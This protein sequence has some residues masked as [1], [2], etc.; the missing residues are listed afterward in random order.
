MIN[1][2]RPVGLFWAYFY[3]G[4][5]HRKSWVMS[6]CRELDLPALIETAATTQ[7][8]RMAS[9]FVCSRP[10]LGNAKGSSRPE[11]EFRFADQAA[12]H[13]NP[14]PTTH[15]LGDLPCLWLQMVIPAS[16]SCHEDLRKETCRI[17]SKLSINAR[18][19]LPITPTAS[20]NFPCCLH[21]FLPS[22]LSSHPLLL[23]SNT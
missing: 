6:S 16:K 2:N 20:S 3:F 19:L 17:N 22:S 5:K 14:H 11:K 8:D 1:K 4:L 18:P 10:W 21:P 9:C 15:Q 7:G 12:L 23:P 13:S